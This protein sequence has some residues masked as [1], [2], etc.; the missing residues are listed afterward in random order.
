MIAKWV[1]IMWILCSCGHLWVITGCFY[2]IIHSING[3]SSV[4]LTGISGHNCMDVYDRYLDPVQ[5]GVIKWHGFPGT[6]YHQWDRIE[7]LDIALDIAVSVKLTVSLW[8][9]G[10]ITISFLMVEWLLHHPHRVF[11][12]QRVQVHLEFGDFSSVDF[13]VAIFRQ[14]PRLADPQSNR[15]GFI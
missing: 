4:L 13:G 7:R 11:F 5:G 15:Q 3:V 12:C 8:W 2:A 6:S 9:R 1:N 10:E 14:T